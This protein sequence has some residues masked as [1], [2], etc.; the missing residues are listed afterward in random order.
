MTI[1]IEKYNQSLYKMIIENILN[2]T[3][4]NENSIGLNNSQ[5][6]EL[7]YC[8]RVLLKELIK[9]SKTIISIKIGRNDPC[10]CGSGKKF[11]KCCG[12]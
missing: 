3:W 10:S 7:I 5:K 12:N 11:K 1:G 6:Q 8:E 2:D 4:W 9:K